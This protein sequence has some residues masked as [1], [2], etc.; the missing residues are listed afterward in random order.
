MKYLLTFS[1][2]FLSHFLFS[3]TLNTSINFQYACKYDFDLGRCVSEALPFNSLVIINVKDGK[4]KI[5]LFYSGK[6]QIF[7]INY[8]DQIDNKSIRFYNSKGTSSTLFWNDKYYTS[9]TID[10]PLDNTAMVFTN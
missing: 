4:G 3:Q 6:K 9:F 10:N 2:I 8:C 5:S 7:Y 1:F